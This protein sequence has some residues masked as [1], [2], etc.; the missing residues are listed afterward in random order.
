MLGECHPPIP[1]Y[2]E[3]EMKV[4]VDDRVRVVGNGVNFGVGI[5]AAHD[6]KLATVKSVDKGTL[7][8]LIDGEQ[9]ARKCRVTDVT[10]ITKKKGGGE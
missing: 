8:V 5:A 2:G 9:Y 7:M 4:S 3:K 10:R 1:V 6:G